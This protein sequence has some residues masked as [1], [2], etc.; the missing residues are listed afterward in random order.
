MEQVT[1]R[2]RRSLAGMVPASLLLF[3]WA[4]ESAELECQQTLT[5]EE[6]AVALNR[7]NNLMGKYSHL[8]MLR[9]EGTTR[10]LFAMNQPDV[11]W[12]TPM[13]P[14]GPEDMEDRFLQPGE[15]P[16]GAVGGQLHM[17]AMLTPVIEIAADGR[18][19]QGVWDS[20]G[21]NISSG[22]SPGNWL[23]LK[24]GVDFIVEDGE[25][26]IWHMQVFPIFNTPYYV[27]ITDNARHMAAEAARRAAAGP[28][29]EQGEGGPAMGG[30]GQ[31]WS[32][33][34]GGDLWIYDGETAPRGPWVP[35]PHCTYD[36]EKSSAA[37]YDYSDFAAED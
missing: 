10:N 11:F 28:G 5:A 37:Y 32:G 20:F 8:G 7:I 31:N 18:T 9:G 3:A 29:G 26:K 16:P 36:P 2:V 30:P 22:D 33:P 15:A 1:Q 34:S 23:W 6:H 12:K 25:W 19:A 17:H 21:P 24:Y 4:A 27:S 14:V 13:G 35:E